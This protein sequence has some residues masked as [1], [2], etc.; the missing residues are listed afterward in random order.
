MG[1][2]KYRGATFSMEKGDRWW[3]IHNGLLA[4]GVPDDSQSRRHTWSVWEGL[5]VRSGGVW[6][7][8]VEIAQQL[9]AQEESAPIPPIVK[10]PSRTMTR[11]LAFERGLM[12]AFKQ[13][14][15][16]MVK[17][18][19]TQGTITGTAQPLRRNASH[20]AL[21]G[22]L[23]IEQFRIALGFSIQALFDLTG[24]ITEGA[25]TAFIEQGEQFAD[26]ELG[27]EDQLQFFNLPTPEPVKQALIDN[28]GSLITKV[29]TELQAKIM[30]AVREGAL[31]GEAIPGITKRIQEVARFSFSRAEMIARTEAIRAFAS[32]AKVRYQR[33]GVERVMWLAALDERTDEDCENLHGEI[34]PI[35]STPVDPPLHPRCRCTWIPIT[36]A[37]TR[38]AETGVPVPAGAVFFPVES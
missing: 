37:S 35:N 20:G 22:T 9:R 18:V 38:P 30:A 16:D 19:Q 36:R 4:A 17:L 26:N 12:G 2:T 14:V 27:I 6:V 34:F 3:G 32:A 10:D 23:T 5:Y 28:T 21:H 1:T 8:R 13:L 33:A 25:I 15:R 24:E 31:S 29:T 7:R 11:R